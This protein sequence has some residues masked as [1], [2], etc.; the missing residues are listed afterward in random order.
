MSLGLL[1]PVVVES[2]ANK[3]RQT[4]VT[5]AS[6]EAFL[7]DRI[8]VSEVAAIYSTSTN[9]ILDAMQGAGIRP[10]YDNCNNVSRFFRK[11]DIVDARVETS[12]LRKPRT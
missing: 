9:T 11:A 5:V 1:K 4:V 8:L 6:L 12:Q 10:I 3:H 2:P 7:E